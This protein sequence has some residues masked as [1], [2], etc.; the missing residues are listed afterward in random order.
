MSK[1]TKHLGFDSGK[2]SGKYFTESKGAPHAGTGTASGVSGAIKAGIK[3][4]QR[5]ASG[6]KK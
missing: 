2:S 4:V 3:V 5:D 6:K 1:S